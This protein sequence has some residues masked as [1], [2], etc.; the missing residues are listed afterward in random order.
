VADTTDKLPKFIPSHLCESGS[1]QQ[2]R[3]LFF[4]VALSYLVKTPS[5][6]MALSS[7][8]KQQQLWRETRA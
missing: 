8:A 1:N 4:A 6:I 5:L 7:T 2:E 3:G